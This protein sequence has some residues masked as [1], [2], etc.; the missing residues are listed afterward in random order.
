M[1]IMEYQS[2]HG[3]NLLKYRRV[4]SWCPG[5]RKFGID[6]R[7][8]TAALKNQSRRDKISARKYGCC[9]TAFFFCRR[10]ADYYLL[11]KK[12][13]I[14]A[15]LCF[16]DYRL[17]VCASG[18]LITVIFNLWT[19]I[20]FSCLHFGQYKGKFLSTVSSR[21]FNLVLLPH[22]GQNIHSHFIIFIP[23]EHNNK[24]ST[25]ITL[26][27][28]VLLAYLDKVPKYLLTVE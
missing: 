11:S 7:K 16:A 24:K 25:S 5:R 13:P 2:R 17:C 28:G 6:W 1:G 22:T 18:S 19:L 9:T 8:E 23:H 27:K 12:E 21:I 10:T 14:T 3:S 26:D 15:N 20:R 4:S